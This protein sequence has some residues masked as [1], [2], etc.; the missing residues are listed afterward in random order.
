MGFGFPPPNS[1][2]MANQMEC[3]QC[4]GYVRQELEEVD[5]VYQWM[6]SSALVLLFE[7]VLEDQALSKQLRLGHQHLSDLSSPSFSLS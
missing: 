2:A 7:P 5:Q 1:G 4:R 3:V 6:I